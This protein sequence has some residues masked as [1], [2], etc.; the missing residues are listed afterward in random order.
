MKEYY[1]L[2]AQNERKG[3]ITKEEL[4]SQNLDKE[5]LVWREGLENWT[6]IKDIAE[7]AEAIRHKTPPPL[8]QNFN[9]EKEPPAISVQETDPPK[10]IQPSK[11]ETAQKREVTKS[12]PPQ[13]GNDGKIAIIII[14]IILIIAGLGFGGWYLYNHEQKAKQERY[15]PSNY[16]SVYDATVYGNGF[17][18][19][20]LR[21]RST[22]TTYGNIE[23]K[24]TYYDKNDR[25]IDTEFITL[26]NTI[27]PNLTI[28]IDQQIPSH[29]NRLRTK[30]INTQIISARVIS[31]K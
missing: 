19:C 22:Y 24:I 5:T 29:S 12:N 30:Y 13:K 23:V 10:I 15:S 11:I 26:Y 27:S 18:Q 9:N 4:L 28:N 20:S 8:P 31:Q 14:I 25:P 16:I 6:P 17:F 2:D 1:Y 21:N 7:L 3:P